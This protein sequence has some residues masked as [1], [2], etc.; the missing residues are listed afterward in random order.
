M[1]GLRCKDM[2]NLLSLIGQHCRRWARSRSNAGWI[3]FKRFS[4]CEGLREE[5][6]APDFTN[7]HAGVRRAPRLSRSTLVRPLRG[8]ANVG[9][10]RNAD[11][12]TQRTIAG[13]S[14]SGS[15]TRRGNAPAEREA[16]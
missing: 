10:R 9:L 5:L 8:R 13:N 12:R 14:L 16:F 1:L 11:R 4:V 2:E 6:G 7:R 15:S 3:P